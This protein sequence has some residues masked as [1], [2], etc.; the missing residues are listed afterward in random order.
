MS[1]LTYAFTSFALL[2]APVAQ[3]AAQAP[4]PAMSAGA[5]AYLASALDSLQQVVL[6]S[7]TIA[8]RTVRDS[9]LVIAAG[10]QKPSDTYA[11]IAW[12]LRRANKH[13]FLQAPRP[14]AVSQ[15][16]DGRIGY[17]HVPQWSGGSASLADSLQTAIRALDSARVC[18]WI[19]DVR[20]NGGGNMW[21]MLA[22]IGPLLGDTLVGA[23]NAGPKA[24]RWFY[25]NGLAGMLTA[26]GSLDTISRA[27][28]A[29]AHVRDPNAPVAVLFDGATGSSGEVVVL[30]FRGRNNTRSFGEP[31]SGFATSNRGLQLADGANMVVT[32]GYQI[33]RRGVEAGERVQPDEVITGPPPGWPFATDV[34]ATAAAAWLSAHPA[35]KR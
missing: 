34:V 9:A 26:S 2:S 6:R 7:D 21:P 11:A 33:D 25:K 19:V 14:G 12:A 4:A 22:G 10:A 27:T 8:W 30:A 18:G 1:R 5:R 35:C 23:F 16:V 17:V 20:A 31:T 32:T 24:D 3:L 28:V 13:S 29:P 15:V